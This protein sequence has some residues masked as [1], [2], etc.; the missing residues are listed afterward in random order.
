MDDVYLARTGTEL[1]GPAREFLRGAM[2][3][4]QYHELLA[5]LTKINHELDKVKRVMAVV[6]EVMDQDGLPQ[7]AVEAITNITKERRA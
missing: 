3:I 2:T 1:C 7:W 5:M 4:N 6:Q